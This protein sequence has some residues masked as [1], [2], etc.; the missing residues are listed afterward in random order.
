[1]FL[2]TLRQGM[3]YEGRF[4]LQKYALSMEILSEGISFVNGLKRSAS[5]TF[6]LPGHRS[7]HAAGFVLAV[8]LL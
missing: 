8:K 2:E 7:E 1:M 3:L 4:S 5:L 6:K